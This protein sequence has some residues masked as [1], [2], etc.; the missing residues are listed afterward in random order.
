M[1][2]QSTQ[3]PSTIPGRRFRS[4]A[5]QFPCTVCGASD[6]TSEGSGI[7]VLCPSHKDYVPCLFCNTL[8]SSV[9]SGVNVFCEA[10]KGYIRITHQCD[11]C[12]EH[13]PTLGRVNAHQWVEAHFGKS[14]VEWEM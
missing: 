5:I 2:M 13:F 14:V 1:K 12:K 6:G 8:T 11:E 10:H 7:P 4:A 9:D 3:S